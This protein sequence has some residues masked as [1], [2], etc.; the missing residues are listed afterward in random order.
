MCVCVC[1][2]LVVAALH[3]AAPI[4]N[5]AALPTCPNQMTMT[6]ACKYVC[7]Y[8]RRTKMRHERR[9]GNWFLSQF[10]RRCQQRRRFSNLVTFAKLLN[11]VRWCRLLK[12]VHSVAYLHHAI[13]IHESGN[14]L[15]ISGIR[16][17]IR[18]LLLV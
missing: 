18:I 17:R 6:S 13:H 16:I 11:D 12:R 15:T 7:E 1:V 2:S 9:R 8:V 5:L 14:V 10:A 4:A 3:T